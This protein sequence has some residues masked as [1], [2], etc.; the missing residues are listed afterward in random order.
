MTELKEGFLDNYFDIDGK[1][2]IGQIIQKPERKYKTVSNFQRKLREEYISI[3]KSKF[4]KYKIPALNKNIR[5]DIFLG[6]DKYNAYGKNIESDYEKVNIDKLV[7]NTVNVKKYMILKII[8]GIYIDKD[9]GC[10][11]ICED[12]NKDV[13]IVVINGSE[14]YFDAT[15]YNMLEKNIYTKEKYIAIIEPNYGIFESDYDEIRIDSPTE[16]IIF[17]DKGDLDYFI[18]K[19]ANV[20]SENYKLIGNLMLNNKFYEKAIFYYNKG[21]NLNGDE[22]NMD[23]VLHSNLAE[24]YLKFGYYSRCI[25]NSDYCLTKINKL[26]QKDNKDEFLTQQKIKNLFR[27]IKS[28]VELRNFKEAYEILYN[29]SE[30]NQYNDIITDVLKLEQMKNYIDIIKIGYQN[31]LGHFDFKKMLQE[32]KANFD[33]SN[34]GDYLNPK[35]EIKSEKGKGIKMIAK[36]KI[37]QGELLIFEKALVYTTKEYDDHDYETKVSKDNPKIMA[38]MEMFNILNIKLR[39]APLDTEKFYYLFDG[40]NLT[41]DLNERK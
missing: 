4:K 22:Y 13:I 19:S 25:Q 3:H 1:K 14:L 21:I 24:A 9:K 32:E 30:S 33:F 41:Q 34:F 18:N 15:S 16:I 6:V 11:F 27:K 26:M 37:N 8:S 23:I 10:N 5:T 20:S 29:K 2:F 12:S 39:K 31:S 17:K 36:E 40:K 35:I 38:E 7:L 28:L